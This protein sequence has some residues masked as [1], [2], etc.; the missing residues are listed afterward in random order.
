MHCDPY[1]PNTYLSDSSIAHITGEDLPK[2]KNFKESESNAKFIFYN[3]IDAG[4][5][6]KF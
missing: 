5:N 6:Q 1:L 2:L 3:Q 4:T